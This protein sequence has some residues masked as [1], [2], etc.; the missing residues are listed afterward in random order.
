MKAREDKFLADKLAQYQNGQLNEEE[1]TIIEKWFEDKLKEAQPEFFNDEVKTARLKAALTSNINKAVENTNRNHRT[2]NDIT[3]NNKIDSIDNKNLKR[4]NGLWLKIAASVL[5]VLGLSFYYVHPIKMGAQ[6]NPVSYR[7]FKNSNGEMMKINLQDGTEI[8]MNASTQIRVADNLSNRKSRIV[9]LDKGEAYFHVK[10]DPSRPFSIT[11]GKFVTT[12]LGTSFNIKSYP[13][14]HNYQVAVSS[15]K[16]K[17]ERISEGKRILLSS[18]LVKDQ[19]LNYSLTKNTF[20]L[21]RQQAALLSSWKTDGSLYFDSLTLPEIG[22]ALERRYNIKVEVTHPDLAKQTYSMKLN[23]E[24]IQTMLQQIARKT[25]MNYQL[26]N[27]KL[28]INP[29]PE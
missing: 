27:Q 16:V 29:N 19:V 4:S 6:R 11:T 24:P 13:E 15:G 7:T 5:I 23:H 20:S 14:L 21:S 9:F 26:T 12:V 10:R 18:G 1:K 8:W 22:A 17:V 3:K 25:G 2:E 28:T